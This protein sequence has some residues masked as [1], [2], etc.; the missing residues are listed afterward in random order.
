[1]NP[2]KFSG[3]IL[4][5]ALAASLPLA[6]LADEEKAPMPQTR[7]MQGMDPSMHEQQAKDPYEGCMHRKSGATT[8]DG[9]PDTRGMKGM[10][11]KAH[12]MDCPHAADKGA[13][14]VKKQK[15]VH[16][17]PPGQN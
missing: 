9:M 6:V 11:P 8:K 1:M 13:A 16:K 7:G 15:H 12:E 17:T 2:I 14:T 10:D 5:L 3:S 4:A